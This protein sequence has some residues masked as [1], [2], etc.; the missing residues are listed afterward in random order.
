MQAKG[1]EPQG[2]VQ[3]KFVVF[4]HEDAEQFLSGYQRKMLIDILGTIQKGR[5]IS[6]KEV[7]NF[8]L[9]INTDEP[10]ANE[11]IDIMKKNNHWG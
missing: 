3:P 5:A 8:Y 10:Y 7:N 11:V 4:K 6:G 1:N 2:S 9:V